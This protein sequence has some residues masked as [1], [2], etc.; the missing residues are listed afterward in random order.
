MD[1]TADEEGMREQLMRI[2][3]LLLALSAL[4]E[5]ACL[6]SRS[7]RVSVLCYLRPAEEVAWSLIAEEVVLSESA[8]EGGDPA[9]VML[10]AARFRA[11]AL[12]LAFLACRFGGRVRAGVAP[13]A[14]GAAGNFAG[15]GSARPQ[16]FDTS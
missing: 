1:W 10:L 16:P 2:V 8:F 3:V 9:S 11:L 15:R 7:V 12:A 4:A 5:R 14:A 6:A 13:M